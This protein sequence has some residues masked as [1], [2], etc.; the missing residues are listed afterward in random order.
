MEALDGK[1]LQALSLDSSPAIAE[2][3]AELG[4]PASTLHQRVKRLEAK[5]LISG[6]RAVIDQRQ[7]GLKLH[8]LV[9]LTP[10]DPARPDDVPEVMAGIAEVE[11]CWSVA[12][13]E[14]YV[15]KVAVS[16]PEELEALLARIRALANVSSTSTVILSTPFEY[17]Q[18]AI[19]EP[20]E[21]Q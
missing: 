21:D 7:A 12:G 6:Y 9:S 10:I 11:S 14:S 8:A 19:P 16:E 17:R 4:I 2:L 20:R 15:I 13:H 3:A 5:G 1:I 18:A